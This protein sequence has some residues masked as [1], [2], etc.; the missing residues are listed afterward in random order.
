MILLKTIRPDRVLFAAT[1]FI[2][3]KIGE[4]FI[5][6]PPVAFDKIFED[7]SKTTPIIFILAPGVDP[8]VQ[9]QQLAVQRERTLI[10]VSLGQGQAKKA[11]E[12]VY[13]GQKLG[14]WLYLANCHLSLNFLKELE[15]M[16]EQLE[17]SKHEVHDNFRLWLSTDPH[18]QFPI[19]IL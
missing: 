11:K 17:I 1:S 5:N 18:P 3:N 4:Y 7:S 13:E 14:H 6:P 19:T 16:I 10:P 8:Y 12:K 9:L 2:S 15:K